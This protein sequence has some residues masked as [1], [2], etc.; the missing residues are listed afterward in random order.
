MANID[1]KVPENVEGPYYVDKSCIS[2]QLCVD[3]AP[4]HFRMAEANAN[5]YVFKQPETDMEKKNCDDAL[6]TCPVDAIG[7]DG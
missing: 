3:R 7:N 1:E 6:E 5:S 4:G 2:C